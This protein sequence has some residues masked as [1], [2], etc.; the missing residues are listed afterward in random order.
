[1]AR[2]RKKH[3][4]F[5]QIPKFCTGDMPDGSCMIFENK[6]EDHRMGCIEALFSAVQ[7]VRY[8]GV[9]AILE[10]PRGANSMFLEIRTGTLL[11]MNYDG[12][13]LTWYEKEEDASKEITLEEIITMCAI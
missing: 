6:G 9:D 13:E 5:N 7:K 11:P 12:M 10:E 1:M 2:K 3:E 4:H 8:E